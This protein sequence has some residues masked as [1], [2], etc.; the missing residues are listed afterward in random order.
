MNF[1]SS[2]LTVV[3]WKV[4]HLKIYAQYKMNLIGE[5]NEKKNNNKLY[6]KLGRWQS[7]DEGPRRNWGGSDQNSLY[8]IFKELIKK[9]E[10]NYNK[11]KYVCQVRCFFK[12]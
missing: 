3:Q 5:K 1:A 11:M 6:A 12:N 10:R 8:K 2:G 9:K 4:T 7:G